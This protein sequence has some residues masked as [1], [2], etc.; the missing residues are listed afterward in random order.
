MI[1]CCW[2]VTACGAPASCKLNWMRQRSPA[3]F[4]NGSHWLEVCPRDSWDGT[5]TTCFLISTDHLT[6]VPMYTSSSSSYLAI[7]IWRACKACKA[8]KVSISSEMGGKDPS[9]S[10]SGRSPLGQCSA[11]L[12]E[13]QTWEMAAMDT[14]AGGCGSCGLRVC[15][16]P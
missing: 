1:S 13:G 16:R 12:S 9:D 15:D 7:G 2:W 10:K 11:T 14:K 4:S 3:A 5:S 8:R 6:P